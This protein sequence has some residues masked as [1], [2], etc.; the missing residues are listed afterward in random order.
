MVSFD[1]ILNQ[2]AVQRKR[3]FVERVLSYWVQK[4]QSRNN[5][6]LIRRLQA[7][8]QP[9]KAKQTV[10]AADTRW[11]LTVQHD[12]FNVVLTEIKFVCFVQDR[13][14]TNQ[15]LKEQLKEWHRLRHDLERARLL[16]EL[17]RKR[18]KLKREEV[19]S[20]H[21]LLLLFLQ[22]S[23]EIKEC[24]NNDILSGYIFDLT[25]TSYVLTVIGCLYQ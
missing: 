6:P 7:N 1:T 22:A 21:H 19:E 10:S 12:P 16:L 20:L 14:E 15:A 24:I 3:L 9:P 2:V 23:F 4:R 5:V 11:L 8:P 13:M 17:I 18:E 25:T